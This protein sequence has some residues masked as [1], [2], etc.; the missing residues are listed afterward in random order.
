VLSSSN[1][2]GYL[3]EIVAKLRDLADQINQSPDA[4]GQK[5]DETIHTLSQLSL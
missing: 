3:K 5:I 4:V 2:E 1:I